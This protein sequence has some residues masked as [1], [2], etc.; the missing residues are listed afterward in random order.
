M[1]KAPRIL[2]VDDEPGV[3][4]TLKAI[5]EQEGYEVMAALTAAE[6]QQLI[7]RVPFDAALLDV[8]IDAADGLDLL[9]EL[10]EC[11]P[12]CCAIMLTG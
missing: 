4:V 10:Q 3:T 6:A 5:L 8:R 1:A 11:Q 7:A 2:I 12:D 9:A